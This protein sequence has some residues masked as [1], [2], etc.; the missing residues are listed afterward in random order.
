MTAGVTFPFV[1]S[2]F[3]GHRAA[4]RGGELRAD[5]TAD[6]ILCVTLRV[7]G[8]TLGVTLG[9][10]GVTLAGLDLGRDPASDRHVPRGGEARAR[11]VVGG[12]EG[13]QFGDLGQRKAGGGGAAD[14]AEA[15]EVGLVIAANRASF[16]GRGAW[17][18]RGV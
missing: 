9:V 6:V 16:G 13:D 18:D 15:F 7:R 14:E 3:A 1:R 17:V 10:T 4:H 12:V 11:A 2:N 5:S 8:V